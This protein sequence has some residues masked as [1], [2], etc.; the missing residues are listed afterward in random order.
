MLHMPRVSA[1]HRIGAR[2]RLGEEKEVRART[3]R[4]VERRRASVDANVWEKQPFGEKTLALLRSRSAG[5]V[6]DDK[7]NDYKDPDPD[8]TT[9]RRPHL[10][11]HCGR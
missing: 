9:D 1:K 8:K 11:K 4:A 5:Y 7:R 10:V 3:A 6:D 2:G